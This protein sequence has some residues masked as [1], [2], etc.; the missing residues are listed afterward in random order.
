[1]IYSYFLTALRNLLKHKL[2]ASINVIG[3]AVAFTC[4]ILL[5][6]LVFYEFSYDGFQKNGS[7]LF[8]VYNV[9]HAAKGDEKGESMGYPMAPTLKAEVP[10]LV[11]ATAILNA[12]NGISYGDK[13][14]PSRISLVDNDFFSMFTFPIVA[15]NTSSPLGNLNEVVINQTTATALFGKVDPVGK[16]VK[17]KVAGEWKAL[18]VSA[19]IQDAPE[20][21]SLRYAVLARIETIHD[22]PEARN[23]W[24]QQNHPV[25]VQL[26][27]G[28][29]QQQAE[30][31]MRQVV[32]KYRLVDEAELKKEGYHKDKNGDMFALK[33]AAFPTL[34]F[35]EELG[36]R[37]AVNKTYLYTLILIAVVVMVIACFNFINLNVARSLTRAK[38]VGI[39][40]TIG[41]GKGQIF[42][43]MWVESLLLYAIAV[44]V[45]LVAASLV[46]K[47]F[48]DLFT[49]KLKL[50]TLLQ[51]SVILTTL[52]AMMLVSFLAGGYPA[53][54]VA[55]F[56]VVEVLKGKVS[57]RR[58]AL[59]RN[60]L[61]T[62]QFVT[63]SALI[64]GTLV[65]YRQ[66]QHLRTASLGFEQ[67]SVISIPVKRPEKVHDYIAQLRVKLASQPQFIGITGSSANIGIGED[68]SQSRSAMGFDYEGKHIQTGLLAV[69]YDFLKVLSM[70]PVSGRDFSRDYVADTA[71]G[72]TNVIVTANVAAQL[73]IKEAGLSLYHDTAAPRWRVVGIIPDFH[74][75][76]MNEA[77]APLTLQMESRGSLDYIL[78]KVQTTNPLRTMNLIKSAY[79]EIEP[80]NTISPSYLTDNT[81]RWYEKEQRLATT[82]FS[83]AFI[84][85]LLSCLGLFAIVFLVMEQRRKEIGVRKVLGASIASITGLLAKDFLLLVLLAFVIATPLA[86]YFLHQWLNNFTYRVAV[87]W[88]IF[89]LAGVLTLLI[90]LLTIGVQTVRAALTNPVQSLRSE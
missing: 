30:A 25:Y 88:W 55:R 42:L 9:S 58:S 5:F 90:A 29:T 8:M 4:S 60:G 86:W 81:Q 89:P 39:R 71:G 36:V 87:D 54:L 77:I 22:Y 84:A 82:F 11:K 37:N 16:P 61:I 26:D 62:F 73:G 75:Y 49:E 32:K 68:K 31:A 3:L 33:L 50:G 6:L 76:S 85:I 64:C 47:P 65:I 72:I 7:R 10:G 52:G 27:R 67:E 28:V 57:V 17:V 43:Q 79:K 74:L 19:V 66:F 51:P 34:H 38:E 12:G 24:N 23:N 48:N 46:L 15:G 18:M 35:D 63:A 80:D 56:N 44:L 78:V 70:K 13:E 45:A 59:L 83:A 21:S 53:W 2:N 14:V 41:A 69:D 1:M 20:N 40:K